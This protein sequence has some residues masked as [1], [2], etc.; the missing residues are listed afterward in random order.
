MQMAFYLNLQSLVQVSDNDVHAFG[1]YER[2]MDFKNGVV[3]G[4]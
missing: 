2:L 4:G 3:F 1:I